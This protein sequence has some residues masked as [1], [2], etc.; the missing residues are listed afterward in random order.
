MSDRILFLKWDTN[1]FQCKVGKIVLKQS[2]ITLN[3]CL[4]LAFQEGFKFLYIFSDYI[5]SCQKTNFSSVFDV[6]GQI[7]FSKNLYASPE[8][9][10]SPSNINSFDGET[11]PPDILKLAYFSGHL[12]RFNI[13]PLISTNR[14]EKMY[15]LWMQ[16]T[17]CNKPDSEIYIYNINNCNVALVTAEFS[18]DHCT[19]GLIAV[20]AQFQGQGIA[21]KLLSYVQAECIQRNISCLNVKTQLINHNAISLYKKNGFAEVERSFLYHAHLNN[22][23]RA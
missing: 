5:I 23:H 22:L 7:L 2:D 15:A 11:L 4:K 18:K 1:F 20:S 10:V 3:A 6:G 17:L 12:S 9:I 21:S 13:D 8:N 14:F 19:I 16:N